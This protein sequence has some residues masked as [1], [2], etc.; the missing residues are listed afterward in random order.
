MTSGYRRRF[1]E[2]RWGAIRGT[3]PSPLMA[4]RY[5][6]NTPA[7]NAVTPDHCSFVMTTDLSP[8]LSAAVTPVLLNR[9]DNQACFYL[10]SVHAPQLRP[11]PRS[12]VQHSRPSHTNNLKGICRWNRQSNS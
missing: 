8:V 3:F 7:P 9:G 1:I 5:L 4:A 12:N 2:V 11:P 6:N 10:S